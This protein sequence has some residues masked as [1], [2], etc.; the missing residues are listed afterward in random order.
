MERVGKEEEV[1]MV[2][3]HWEEGMVEQEVQEVTPA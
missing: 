1:G 3:E 2:V